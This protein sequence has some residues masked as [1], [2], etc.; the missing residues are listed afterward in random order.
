MSADS[1]HT[2]PSVS[3]TESPFHL[4]GT[5]P[6]PENSP[7]E[8]GTF[9]VVRTWVR[10]IVLTWSSSAERLPRM[11]LL[12]HL[13]FPH[14]CV[15]SAMDQQTLFKRL[16]GHCRSRR[17]PVSAYQDEVHH[18]CLPPQHLVAIRS[19]LPRHLERP[20]VACPHAQIHAHVPP[21]LALLT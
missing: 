10:G 20:M 5:F 4:V 15:L 6:G 9:D 1:R 7:Y 3:R 12:T 18:P 17:I 8:K 16:T 11:L 2:F 14:C 19:H 21:I 13:H